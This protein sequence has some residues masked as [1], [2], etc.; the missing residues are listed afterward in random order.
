MKKGGTDRNRILIKIAST[1]EGIKAAEQLEREG[2]HCKPD[3][4][5]QPLPK[6][7]LALR[8]RLPLISPFRLAASTDWY[9]KGK[10]RQRD[11]GG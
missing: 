6:P 2:I 3:L 9:K 8:Q 4:V 1:W 10:W 5:V 7:L 11:S